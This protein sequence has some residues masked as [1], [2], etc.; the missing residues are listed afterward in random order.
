MDIFVTS[1]VTRLAPKRE[2]LYSMQE[3]I[4]QCNWL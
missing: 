4:P 3:F 2:S 1:K